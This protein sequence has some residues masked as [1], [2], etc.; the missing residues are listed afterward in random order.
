[1]FTLGVVE[2]ESKVRLDARGNKQKFPPIQFLKILNPQLDEV[3][4]KAC[5]VHLRSSCGNCL[6]KYKGDNYE[7][8]VGDCFKT[9][10]KFIN[11]GKKV[12][13]VFGDLTDI[14]VDSSGEQ[15]S[16]EFIDLILNKSMQVLKPG[17]LYLTHVSYSPLTL[18]QSLNL[19][20]EMDH[21]FLIR[22]KHSKAS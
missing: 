21:R 8:I 7:I 16:W 12:D 6:D 9:L 18:I 22:C 11:E 14:P 13:F 2:R 15:D 10:N 17:G 19:I 3:V 20:R 1:M 5:S 4:M